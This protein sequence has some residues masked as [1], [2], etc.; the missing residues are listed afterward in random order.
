MR[1]WTAARVPA[2]RLKHHPTTIAG[3]R[4]LLHRGPDGTQSILSRPQAE[5]GRLAEVGEL[6]RV[7]HR[8]DAAD[9]AVVD[10]EPDDVDE[11]PV[12]HRAEPRLAVDPAGFER[13]AQR[14][15]LAVEG[16][17]RAG[18][19]RARRPSAAGSSGPCRR[20]RRRARRPGR[21]SRRG[22]RGRPRGRRRGS[23]RRARGAR[24]GR[25]RSAGR[26]S[27]TRRRARLRIWRQLSSE[28]VD[29][30][31]R[32]RRTA[33]RTT[34]A[35][36]TP[37]ARPGVRRSSS[38]RNASETV[39]SA[40][41]TRG[42]LGLDQRLGQP[43][44]DVGLAAHARRAQDVD[45]Q[46]RRDRRQERRARSRRAGGRGAAQVRLLH[47]V[48]GLGDAAEHPV[49]DR[50]EQRAQRRRRTAVTA[51]HAV[52]SEGPCTS[53]SQARPAPSAAR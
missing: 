53:S 36:R 32:S 24:P 41:T 29:D 2:A 8:V 39:S 40:S 38:T 9:P 37:R 31:R 45:R 51:F 44:A 33:S 14:V 23:A 27:S 6:V 25:R 49:G 26:S 30:L 4:P 34:R 18:D 10:V 28:R 1:L 15:D 46:P 5:A 43:R 42:R 19:R 16:D 35:A 22:R 11:P 13:H 50:E 7:E 3:D 20:R 47:D 21:A 12:R 17:E 52:S 48:L